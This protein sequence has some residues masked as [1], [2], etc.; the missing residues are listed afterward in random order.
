MLILIAS[1][2]ISYISFYALFFV[3]VVFM[4]NE[5][6]SLA[7]KAKTYPQ[8]VLGIIIGVLLFTISYF[9]A[10]G[11][12]DASAFTFIIPLIFLTFILE[13]FANNSFPFSN[14]AYTLLGVI[15]IALPMSLANY[16]VLDLGV[17]VNEINI[18]P[19]E[20]TSVIESVTSIIDLNDFA[21]RVDFTPNVLLGL[22]FLIWSNDTGAYLVGVSFG[23]HKL[24]PRIS[25]KKSWEGS[26]GG[27]I[28]AIGVAYLISIYFTEI[29]LISWIAIAL[30]SVVS[31]SLGDLVESMFKRSINIK[32]SG[33][34]LPGHGGLLDR[35]DAA[36]LALPFVYTYIKLFI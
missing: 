12:V 10:I 21:R 32:D 14:I 5:F 13:L 24:F 11:I 35:F 4:Q 31:G 25:P 36:I 27:A 3:L 9:N 19:Q 30:V 8:R 29:S 20:S 7:R 2:S 28:T 17:N 34:I 22:F 15:Y 33:R 23:K 6:Y 26:I 18:L 16:L 1:I